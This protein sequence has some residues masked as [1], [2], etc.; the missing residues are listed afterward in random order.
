MTTNTENPTWGEEP[1]PGQT[2]AG[3]PWTGR[4]TLA[5]VA[6]AVG[7]AAV[8]GGVIY[9]ASGSE[10][11]GQNAMGGRGMGMPGMVG[12]D[13]AGAAASPF[14]DSEHGE[15]QVGEVTEVGDG[16]ISVTSADGYAKTYLVDADTVFRVL[17][18]G[19][20][21]RNQGDG[22]SGL[23]DLAVGDSVTVV[24]TAGSDG[25]STA[26]A[27]TERGE[28][29]GFPGGQDGGQGQFPGG[30][31]G[32]G[33]QDGGGQDGGGQNGQQGNGQ[34]GDGQQGNGQGMTPPSR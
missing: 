8:G 16:S 34:G 4:K 23:S 15:F 5:A 14:G 12:G 21:S 10:S 7:I 22:G 11:S 28:Q 9:A 30:Q 25:R 26:D 20:G 3:P 17:S 29:S 19:A 1:Q 6:I 18:L 27:V 31:N 2:P 32:G 24:S 13:G 33:G